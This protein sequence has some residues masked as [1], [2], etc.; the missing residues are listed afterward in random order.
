MWSKVHLY[1]NQIGLDYKRQGEPFTAWSKAEAEATDI[2][3][4]IEEED[5]IHE[6]G[7]GFYRVHVKLIEQTNFIVSVDHRGPLS[8]SDHEWLRSNIEALLRE[9]RPDL[10][11]QN[12]KAEII[13]LSVGDLGDN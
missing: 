1:T 3:L 12:V 7:D 11:E 5:I 2:H 6:N 13:N 10:V 9:V 8:E 4:T